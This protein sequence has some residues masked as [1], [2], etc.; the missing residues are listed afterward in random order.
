[1]ED[2]AP[3]ESVSGTE[4]E[5]R[6][7]RLSIRTQQEQEAK[8]AAKG[9]VG[10]FRVST[11]SLP[12]PRGT[13]A[14]VRSSIQQP[15]D[16]ESSDTSAFSA[17]TP[18]QRRKS[19]AVD[20]TG[21]FRVST[22]PL[23]SPRG[24]RS[25]ARSS[26]QQPENNESSD[27]SSVF[28]A[29]TASQTRNSRDSL[30]S[31]EETEAKARAAVDGTAFRST[32]EEQDESPA[33]R[34]EEAKRR[35]GAFRVGIDEDESA[36]FESETFSE[37]PKAG[38]ETMVEAIVAPD[39]QAEV[40]AALQFVREAA[41]NEAEHLRRRVAELERVN[42]PEKGGHGATATI[43]PAGIVVAVADGADDESVD[44][45]VEEEGASKR[46]KIRNCGLLLLVLAVAGGAAA[47][48]LSGGGSGESAPA[49]SEREIKLEGILSDHTP[50]NDEAFTWLAETDTWEPP[51]DATNA[52]SLWLERY[53]MATIY[54]S[55]NGDMWT[56][57]DSWLSEKPVCDWF[58]R[59]WDLAHCNRDKQVTRLELCKCLFVQ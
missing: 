22:T 12:S 48:V 56:K 2:K 40:E 14:S 4:P 30:R 36:K 10:A 42:D 54:H 8:R 49:K 25:S 41:N 18:N 9:A 52:E 50:S 59:D 51:E 1:M 35:A 58:M 46:R 16:S 5:T 43:A 15:G 20:G 29:L 26:I 53:A 19:R 3:N 11:T 24:T 6:K 17:L 13:R 28:S 34:D 23:S 21:A 27:T 37:T 47:G 44:D 31:R 33:L 39:L 45:S 55:T 7:E 38:G 32:R 57:N